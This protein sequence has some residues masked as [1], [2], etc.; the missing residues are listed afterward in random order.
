MLFSKRL[1][2]LSNFLTNTVG[3]EPWAVF[4]AEGQNAHDYSTPNM[5]L[6]LQLTLRRNT[7]LSQL[8]SLL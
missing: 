5:M 8:H 7:N 3:L 2:S 1:V 4:K 6:I